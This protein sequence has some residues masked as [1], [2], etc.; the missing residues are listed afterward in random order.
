MALAADEFDIA[1]ATPA[2]LGLRVKRELCQENCDQKKLLQLVKAGADL[3]IQN[4]FG[5]NSLML[6]ADRPRSDPGIAQAMVDN[7]T[8]PLETVSTVGT[9]AL[10]LCVSHDNPAFADILLRAGANV[11]ARPREGFTMLGIAAHNAYEALVRV[12]LDHGADLAALNK[13]GI[14]A[15]EAARRA[16]DDLDFRMKNGHPLPPDMVKYDEDK[17]ARFTSILAMIDAEPQRRNRARRAEID[18][19]I[20]EALTQSGQAPAARPRAR[21]RPPLN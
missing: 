18:G 21:F 5:Y 15:R 1:S 9:S 4:E 12:L 14:N 16:C 3:S 20:D 17:L 6:W 13:D 10:S 7:A 19:M 2:E 11:N 8:A